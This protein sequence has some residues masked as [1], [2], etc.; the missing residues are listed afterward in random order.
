MRDFEYMHENRDSSK[1]ALASADQDRI[2][3]T[4]ADYRKTL[5]SFYYTGKYEG[6]RIG[7]IYGKHSNP[8]GDKAMKKELEEILKAIPKEDRK[9]LNTKP[10]IEKQRKPSHE[11]PGHEKPRV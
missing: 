7:Y 11:E 10:I 4:A 3:S 8:A 2:S 9:F 6:I 1:P 5:R